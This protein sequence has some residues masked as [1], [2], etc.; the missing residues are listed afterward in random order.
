MKSKNIL[1]ALLVFCVVVVGVFYTL[2][3]ETQAK[4]VLD[5]KADFKPNELYNPARLSI[6]SQSTLSEEEQKG[7]QLYGR[8]CIACHGVDMPATKALAIVYQ[9][10]DVPALLEDRT[11]LSADVVAAF[12]RYGKH[13]MPFFRKTEISDEEL[14]YLGKYLSRNYQ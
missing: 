9:G 4:S 5:T 3:K 11:D 12:V 6:I 2:D 7:Q 14:V 13:S 1:I 10:S 8:W